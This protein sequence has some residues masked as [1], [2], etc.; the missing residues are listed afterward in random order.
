MK[1]VPI[2]SSMARE[3]GYA[4]GQL[5]VMFSDGS[6]GTYSGVPPV[7]YQTL[8]SAPSFGSALHGLV[9]SRPDLY[10]FTR[11]LTKEQA[12]LS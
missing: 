10:R 3:V 4:N 8:M 11:T 6:I 1:R 12:S 5:E 7:V 2:R 9:R